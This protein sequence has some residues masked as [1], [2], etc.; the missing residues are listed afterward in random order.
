MPRLTMLLPMSMAKSI[1]RILPDSMRYGVTAIIRQAHE[2]GQWQVPTV[3]A[4]VKYGWRLEVS[5]SVRLGGQL[6]E[7]PRS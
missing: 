1:Y 3:G 6:D 4:V 2:I 7:I 5:L